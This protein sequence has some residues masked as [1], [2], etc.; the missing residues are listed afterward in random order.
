MTD[1]TTAELT[2]TQRLVL[3]T[4]LEGKDR[5][6]YPL[7]ANLKG[8]AVAKVANS[9]LQRGLVEQVP[10]QGEQTAWRHREDGT[11]LTLCATKLARTELGEAKERQSAPVTGTQANTE[12]QEPAPAPNIPSKRGSA[13]QALL[14]LLSRPEGATIAELQQ[15][16][17]WQAHSV[18]GASVGADQ[19][20]ARACG[21]LHEG[22]ARPGLPHRWLGRTRREPRCRHL[23]KLAS[24]PSSLALSPVS[25]SHRVTATST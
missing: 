2:N 24:S 1:M 20:E 7:P 18:R 14:A 15:A 19:E 10:A 6:L 23:A 4:A 5:C 8:G 9:L 16:T 13:Q 3:T 21:H 11:R 25:C 22:G 17:G 12:R